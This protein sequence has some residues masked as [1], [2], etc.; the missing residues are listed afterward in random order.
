MKK[1]VLDIQNYKKVDIDFSPIIPELKKI[2]DKT[3]INIRYCL[4]SPFA[5]AHIY[6]NPKI[7]ELVYEIEEPILNKE[8][9]EYR[10]QLISAMRN[11]INYES[12]IEKNQEELLKYIGNRLKILAIE[13]GIN[14]SY[15]SYKKIFY[16]LCRDFIGFNET[17]PLLRDYFVEDIECNGIGTPVYIVHRIYRNLKTNLVFKEINLLESFVEKLAQRCG[18]Y[19]SYAQPIL[20]GSLPDGSR[21][22]ATYTKDIASKG[23][24]FCFANG[25][26]QLGN[27]E[28]IKIE[29]L[30]ER[31]KNN[32]GYKI[33]DDNEVVGINNMTCCGVDE[34]NLNQINSKLK[35]I[36]KL[37]PP[38]KLVRIKFKDGFDITTTTNHLFHISDSD[39]KLVEAVNLKKD[40]FV[41]TPSQINVQGCLQTINL[42]N[43]IKDF[44]YSNKICVVSNTQIKE[45]VNNTISNYRNQFHNH[46]QQLSQEYGVHNSYFYEI[47]SKGHSISFEVLNK[48]C[49]H[50]NGINDIN[51]VVYGGGT[52]GKNKAIKIPHQVDED[53]AYLAGAIISDGHLNRANIDIACYE[54]GFREATISRLIK[55]F[56]KAEVYYHGNRVY[57]CNLFVP[58]FFNKVFEIPCGKKSSTV[59]IPKIIFKSDNK[60][61][62]SFIKGLFD[63]DGTCKSGLSYK[64]NS[65]Q[66]AEE[67]TYLL[68]R[69]GIYSKINSKNNQYQVIIPSIYEEKYLEKIGFD[70]MSKLSCLNKLIDK[71]YNDAK[72]YINSGRVPAKPIL[73][74]IKKL[75][76]TKKEIIEF[77]QVSYNRLIYYDSL[78][79]SFVKKMIPL[80][81]SE[82][83][84]GKIKD[85]NLDYIKWLVN[86]K[87]EFV[88]IQ[89][90]E[91]FDNEKN[92]PVY[93]IELEPCKF[94]IAGNKPM[95]VFDTIR[96]FTKTPWTPPQLIA[97]KTLS[98]EMLAY[99]WLLVQYKMNILI[100]GGTASGKT[101]LLNAIAFFIPPESRVVSIEDS[102]TGDSKIIIKEDEKVKNITIKEF[103]DKKINA[104]VVSLDKNGKIIFTRP[105]NYIK[106]TVKKDIYEVLTATGRK[107]KVTQDHSL[108]SL[109]EKG[110]K[111]IKPTELEQGK[112]FIAVPRTLPIKGTKINE[113]NLM[114]NLLV[115]EN[116]FLQGESLKSLFEKYSRDDL[117]VAKERYRWWKKNNLIKIKEFMK[118]NANFS[119]EELKS[120][121]IKSRNTSSIPVIFKIDKKF[122]EFCGLWLGDGSYDNRNKNVVIISNQDKECRDVF[123][124]IA[125]YLESNYSAMNDGNVSL[126]LH[127]TVF[128][129]LMK[130]VLKFDGYSDTKKIPD[131]IFNLSNEQIKHFIRGYFS[132]DGTV[133]TNEISCSSQSYVLLEDL[134][135]LFLRLNIISRINDFARKDKCMNMSVSASENIEKFKEIGFLQDR[136][137]LNMNLLNK[138]AHHTCSDVIPLSTAKMHEL[139]EISETKLSYPYLKGMQNI[140][141]NYMQKIA[142]V[143]SEFNDLSHS[144]ILWD[145]VKSVKKVSSKEIEVFDLS[146]PKHEKFLC[147][148]IF[149]HNTRELNLPRDNW[150][151]SVVRGATG[152]GNIGEVDLFTLLRSSFRQNPD[153]VIVGEVRGKEAYV[154]FQGMASGH[155]SISTIHAD[156][157]DTVIKR[158]ETPPIELSP[159]LLNV[160][161]CVCIMTHA[162]VK[163]QETR[164]LKEIVEIINVTN[165]G[166][167]LTNTPY[168]WNPVNDEFYFKKNSKIFDKIAKRYGIN[169]EEL[170]LEFRQR[171][172]LLYNL[173]RQKV[174]GFEKVQDVINQYYKKPKEV[175]KK[176]GIK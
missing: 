14:F 143:N 43:L 9:E 55:K 120:L 121:R 81:E 53:L 44:S 156:S 96:K 144:D 92:I 7:Y 164:K 50:I 176:F 146:I 151:P 149:V 27:G 83:K 135:A 26:F 2:N 87:Q 162:I 82:I 77:C 69:L 106:H 116:D 148:N 76:L 104:E 145:M 24:T 35:T 61:V 6:W 39:L 84:K 137:N 152:L 127:S 154:L 10:V 17:E 62:A 133:K 110:L 73:E 101:T 63:G 79:K 40:M 58:Y 169:V 93:D 15:E 175:L 31:C 48:M 66:L 4:V 138:K 36:I 29:E 74:M 21:V 126:R 142:P 102:V 119:Y 114:E 155:S 22:N 54:R 60:V 11:I 91:I 23:P 136:K 171:V 140:G 159:T 80:F 174:F 107:I 70:N 90:V 32:F 85:I 170:N 153:Y 89:S 56:G 99:L 163:K 30:F 112:S 8:E 59:K 98:P 131:F 158:L 72:S 117:G 141:R 86:C 20:D 12:I 64:T 129:K 16:Y 46:R 128:Y 173:Y 118:L 75:G 42:Y 139:N 113:I 123:K 3:Q 47:I 71:K 18:K 172:Q 105:S 150:L 132:A 37:K 68:S 57:L 100:T 33:E 157:V 95:N 168:M 5:Y 166:I 19:I 88:K 67:L 134:Q 94:F 160:L 13:L 115:F 34:K 103:V 45:L 65:K 41:P 122:L 25:Y 38:K 125:K 109:G 167:A 161:D 124:I 165:E 51:I 108:F 1:D 49:S 78:S 130:N 52:K 111:D 97:F 147:N 28:V